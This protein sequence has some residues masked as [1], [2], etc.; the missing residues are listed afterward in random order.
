MLIIP[1]TH[2]GLIC[3]SGDAACQ[4]VFLFTPTSSASRFDFSRTLRFTFLGGAL[5]APVLHIW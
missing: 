2:S 4:G 5:L 3:G 1:H